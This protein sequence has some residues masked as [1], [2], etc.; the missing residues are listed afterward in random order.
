MKDIN[1]AITLAYILFISFIILPL[2][3]CN[4]SSSPSPSPKPNPKP[5]PE[6]RSEINTYVNNL[7]GW[8]TPVTQSTDSRDPEKLKGSF[9]IRPYAQ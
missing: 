9:D 2:A 3:A 8:Q 7:P 6:D 1:K 4:N 5:N